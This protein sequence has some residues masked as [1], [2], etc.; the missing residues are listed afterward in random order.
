MLLMATYFPAVSGFG[1]RTVGLA[2]RAYGRSSTSLYG[3]RCEDRTYQ[4]EELEDKDTCTSEV[5]LQADRTIYFGDTDGPIA[6]EMV[7]RWDIEPDTNNFR[8]AI[9]RTFGAGRD[10]KDSTAMGE[11]SFDGE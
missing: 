5:F 9:R 11:F 6:D 4:L 7:G 8:M 1:G 3:I 10:T 2:S